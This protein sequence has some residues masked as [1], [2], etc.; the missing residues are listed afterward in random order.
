MKM[1]GKN[2]YL[3]LRHSIY[4]LKQASRVWSETFVK[5]AKSIRFQVSSRDPCLY[6][7]IEG[8]D[9][10]FLLVYANNVII[11]EIRSNYK[12]GLAL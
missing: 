5:Y 1:E 2:N 8:S 12:Y 11:T 3:Y 7:K 4:G 10:V 9:F 6:S